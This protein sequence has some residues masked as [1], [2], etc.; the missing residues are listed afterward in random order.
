VSIPPPPGPRILPDPAAWIAD[1][2]NFTELADGRIMAVNLSR[3]QGQEVDHVEAEILKQLAS[4]AT[5]EILKDRLIGAGWD[6][7][8][9]EDLP[10]ILEELAERRLIGPLSRRLPPE[11]LDP[12]SAGPAKTPDAGPFRFLAL[13]TRE[14]PILIRR[15]LEDWRAFFRTAGTP[16][17]AIIISEEDEKTGHPDLPAA[18]GGAPVHLL[19]RTHRRLLTESFSP[20]LRETAAFALGLDDSGIP[21]VSPYGTNRNFLLL[22]TGGSSIL[23]CD[24]DIRPSFRASPESESGLA[25]FSG[26]DPSR[27][28]TFSDWNALETWGEPADGAFLDFHRQFLGRLLN[29]VLNRTERFDLERAD[30]E[31]LDSLSERELRIAGSCICYWGD[32]GIP[33]GSHMLGLRGEIEAEYADPEVYESQFRSRLIHRSPAR[34]AVGGRTLMGGCL[35]LDNSQILPPFSPRGNNEDGLW[36][37]C[38]RLLQPSDRIIY[39]PWAVKHQPDPPREGSRERAVQWRM[40]LN[41]SL[42]LL[43]HEFLENRLGPELP[44]ERYRLL[45][46]LLEELAGL[47]LRVLRQRMSRMVSRIITGRISHLHTVLTEFRAEPEWWARDVRT[48]LENAEDYIRETDFWLPRETAGRP[49]AFTSYLREFSRLI[50]FWP[51]LVREARR[52]APELLASARV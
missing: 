50:Y 38:L 23:M 45:G 35:G 42:L 52:C 1:P 44:D 29:E 36:I 33:G 49:E 27:I 4:P 9:T 39:P 24:D 3:G 20:E 5:A 30:G 19:T 15:A 25:L 26:Q 43:C 22:L 11:I 21:E 37:A 13:P 8:Y 28:R 2:L 48:A 12:P 10:E 18:A 6:P 34:A 41:E 31:Y 40:V 46:R 51:D 47:P 16:V 32:S 17:P 7:E 14:R